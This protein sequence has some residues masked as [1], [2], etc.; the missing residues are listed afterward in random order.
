MEKE[1]RKFPR[2][3]FTNFEFPTVV[4]LLKFLKI[5]NFWNCQRTL[6]SKIFIRPL[7]ACK[8]WYQEILECWI[9]PMN[10]I[11]IG[12]I[13]IQSDAIYTQFS[14]RSFLTDHF[15]SHVHRKMTKNGL[16]PKLSILTVAYFLPKS[17]WLMIVREI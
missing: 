14:H 5:Q 16:L 6:T 15:R 1:S 13:N 4:D 10:Q 12:W 11:L 17:D 7:G 2:Y 8:M 3:D 9:W